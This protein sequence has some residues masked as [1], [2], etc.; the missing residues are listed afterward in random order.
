MNDEILILPI[1]GLGLLIG[2]GVTQIN[3]LWI[4]S[5]PFLLGFAI[6]VGYLTRNSKSK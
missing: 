5:I 1:I 2:Y 4:L 3:I 6:L